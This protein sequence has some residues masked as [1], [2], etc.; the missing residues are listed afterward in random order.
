MPLSS[1]VPSNQIFDEE[2]PQKLGKML[3]AVSTQG[4]GQLHLF[5][6]K[7]CNSKNDRNCLRQKP[8][9]CFGR[10]LLIFSSEK[11]QSTAFTKFPSVRTL[12]IY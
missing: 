12:K 11:L 10:M 2:E 4:L 9:Q 8:V 7:S 5:R 3:E 6:L 1:E